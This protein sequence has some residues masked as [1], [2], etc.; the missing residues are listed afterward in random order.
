M[1]EQR[2]TVEEQRPTIG[3][4]QHL[5]DLVEKHRVVYELWPAKVVHSG[6]LRAVGY[7]IALIGTHD[8]SVNDACALGYD[9]CALV[10]RDLRHIAQALFP[11]PPLR[12]RFWVAP[13]SSAVHYARERGQRPDVE[14]LVEVRH[15]SRYDD[16]V[17]AWEDEFLE[18]FVI[19]LQNLGIPERRW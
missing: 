5:I 1:E 15:R 9:R 17:D 12:V 4:Q 10:W 2:P 19:G 8:G 7:D 16:P 14:L 6:G 11:P 3:E 13:F 18:M